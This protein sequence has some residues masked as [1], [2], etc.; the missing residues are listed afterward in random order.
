MRVAGPH[1]FVS[2]DQ[3]QIHIRTSRWPTGARPRSSIWKP[4]LGIAEKYFPAAAETLSA[5]LRKELDLSAELN[6][7]IIS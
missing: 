1:P 4:D 7:R 3:A 2:L 6:T 5:T